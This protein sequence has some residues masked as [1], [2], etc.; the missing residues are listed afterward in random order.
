MRE[1]LQCFDVTIRC[2]VGLGFAL[3]R[4]VPFG[5]GAIVGGSANYVTMRQ[6]RASALRYYTDRPDL[7]LA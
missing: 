5:V 6:F 4:L 7:E 2:L 3:G 1:A